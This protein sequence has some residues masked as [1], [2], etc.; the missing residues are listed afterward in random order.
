MTAKVRHFNDP[1][2]RF[3]RR[4]VREREREKVHHF[5]RICRAGTHSK[6]GLTVA[7]LRGRISGEKNSPDYN[8]QQS[9]KRAGVKETETERIAETSPT[10]SSDQSVVTRDAMAERRRR[11]SAR[12]EAV[13]TT[14]WQQ[15]SACNG[16][17]DRH[18]RRC[19]ATFAGGRSGAPPDGGDANSNGVFWR[20]IFSSLLIRSFLFVYRSS[21]NNVPP[22]SS[23]VC[24]LEI[25]YR[26]VTW[27][28]CSILL[29]RNSFILFSH[30][31]GFFRYS[32]AFFCDSFRIR[33]YS[34]WISK[35]LCIV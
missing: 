11:K 22:P 30:F 19:F 31:V 34:R 8:R 21:I 9:R 3:P 17:V 14:P 6:R 10:S 24:I 7:I 29:Q 33:K 20:Q 15:L 28:L 26:S 13:S 2:H 35:W 18:R 5:E 27:F 25:K 1:Q 32:E 16:D 12:G 4:R 23:F